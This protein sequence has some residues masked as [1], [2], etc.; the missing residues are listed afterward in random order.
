[1]YL[2]NARSTCT[3]FN[4]FKCVSQNFQQFLTQKHEDYYTVSA[5]GG[6]GG[7]LHRRVHGRR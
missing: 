4:F 7:A 6:G 1:M 5:S 2:L 3:T